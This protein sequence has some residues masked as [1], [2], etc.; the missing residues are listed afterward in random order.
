MAATRK[1]W[2][3]PPQCDHPDRAH[4][5]KGMCQ[6]CYMQAYDEARAARRSAANKKDPSEYA[7]GYR[8]PPRKSARIPDCHPDRKHAAFGLC[9]S[10]YNADRA[11]R[12][13]ADCHPGKPLVADGLCAGCYS[14]RRY[15]QDP[16]AARRL[17]RESHT[18]M[19]KRD[20]GEMVEAYGGRCACPRCPETNPAFLTL[21]HVN[22]D[23]KEHRAKVGSHT[24]ADL[25]K[26]GWPKDGYTLL[27][28]NCNAMTRF[29]RA[30]P[31]MEDG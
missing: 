1:K 2:V 11:Q 19:R 29:G 18:R 25:R 15:D 7:P 16:E 9:D 22:G 12:V 5:A 10:C 27:C 24:Y 26:R 30:C 28:W 23:G 8:N 6:Q 14:K 13:R 31:H 4:F 20:R 21:E 3:G 17:A